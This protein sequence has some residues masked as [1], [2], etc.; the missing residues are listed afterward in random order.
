MKLG[1]LIFCLSTV[2]SAFA[3]N[4]MEERIWRV[5]SR[6]KSI[7]LD[8]GVF[9]KNSDVKSSNIVGL[10]NSAVSGRGYERIVVDFNTSVV[11]KLYGHITTNKKLSI[12]FFD[13]AVVAAQP[14]LKDSKFIKS[15]DFINVDTKTITMEMTLKGKTSFD[16]FYLENPGRLVIDVR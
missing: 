12:D 11:P 7:F 13:T 1:L 9:H 14:Q 10:R 15:V 2:I 3:Q 6:K 5:S 8:S 16:I 4:L